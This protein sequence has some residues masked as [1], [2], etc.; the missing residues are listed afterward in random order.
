[1]DIKPYKSKFDYSYT[2]GAFPTFELIKNQPDKVITVFVSESFTDYDK[3]KALCE[4][5]YVSLNINDKII[6]KLSDKGNVYVVGVFR[7]YDS[8]LSVG[9][10]H[11]M[12]VNPS[13]MGNMGTILRSALAFSIK[14]IAIIA[15]GVDIY[16][17][18]VVR[19]SMGAMFHLNIQY[20]ES[21]EAYQS[22]YN[23]DN[24]T[25]ISFMLDAN[26]PITVEESE[27]PSLFTLI[28]GNEAT[29]L[30]EE[31]KNFTKPVIIPQSSEVDSL[32]LTIAAGIAMY[33][34]NKDNI[35]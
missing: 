18:K 9:K 23:E 28:F 20:F 10:P 6:N 22:V 21:F 25:L 19:A 26:N 4:E 33:T 7:K 31:Y 1:M 3:L 11:A 32:N 27:K 17:P 12:F 35:K 14:D 13:D 29:G 2:L 8:K 5:K 34:F 30:P 15:P 16:N 24:R